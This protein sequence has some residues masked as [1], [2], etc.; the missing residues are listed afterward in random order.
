MQATAREVK[1]DAFGP[2][3]ADAYDP[4]DY[5]YARANGT[6]TYGA[7]EPQREI[8]YV[9]EAWV[10]ATTRKGKS[11]EIEAR[12]REPL[13]DRRRQ[14]SRAQRSIYGDA[15]RLGLAGC[16]LDGNGSTTSRSATSARCCTSSR[17]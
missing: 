13:A 4:D 6:F 9:V 8:P 3:G 11:V 12:V 15:K 2:I 10:C 16:G 1:H 14:R 7:H 5:D 17:R